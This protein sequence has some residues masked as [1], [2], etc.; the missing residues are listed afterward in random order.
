[1]DW[2]TIVTNIGSLEDDSFS[3]APAD[4]GER[5]ESLTTGTGLNYTELD[6]KIKVWEDDTWT[7][8]QIYAES[9]GLLG[10]GRAKRRKGDRR[11]PALGFSLAIRRAYAD[12]IAKEEKDYPL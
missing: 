11:N 4:K 10:Q 5:V 6:V 1:M 3:V 2:S 8:A 9:G 12:A 7:V